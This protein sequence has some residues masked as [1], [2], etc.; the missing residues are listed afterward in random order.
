ML[1]SQS[2]E[3]ELTAEEQARQQAHEEKIKKHPPLGV[4]G[5]TFSPLFIS[6]EPKPR[7]EHKKIA[8]TRVIK[9]REFEEVKRTGP[10]RNNVQS[11]SRFALDESS[12]SSEEVPQPPKP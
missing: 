10:L 8:R 6:L 11:R 9:L 2:E 1:A 7:E 3:E 5:K 4:K 12:S